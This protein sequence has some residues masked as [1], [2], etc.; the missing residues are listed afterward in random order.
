MIQP[1]STEIVCPLIQSPAGEHSSNIAPTRSA[2]GPDVFPGYLLSEYLSER[3][4]LGK[5]DIAALAG[6]KSGGYPVHVYAS[7]SK[8]GGEVGRKPMESVFADAVDAAG[9]E[10]PRGETVDDP[11]SASSFHGLDDGLGAQERAPQIDVKHPIPLGD[12]HVGQSE[13]RQ[14]GH[15]RRVVDQDV[16]TAEVLDGA[17]GHLSR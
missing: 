3:R 13:G 15:D 1:P 11:A 2:G 17:G 16:D 8:F 6:N 9:H 12:G 14:V 7:R 4:I 5:A 10:G